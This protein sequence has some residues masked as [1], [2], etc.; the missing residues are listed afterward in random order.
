MIR[1]V[2][3][4]LTMVALQGCWGFPGYRQQR[5]LTHTVPSALQ[6]GSESDI[7]APARAGGLNSGWSGSGRGLPCVQRPDGSCL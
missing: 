2:C 7:D 6:P 4:A 1:I 3:L 5:G